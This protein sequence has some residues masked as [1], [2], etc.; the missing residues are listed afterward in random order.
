M[1]SKIS[2]KVKNEK[3]IIF[4]QSSFISPLRTKKSRGKPLLGVG[5]S[6]GQKTLSPDQSD[7]NASKVEK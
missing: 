6:S 7:S 2:K 4:P 5:E 3:S 1:I